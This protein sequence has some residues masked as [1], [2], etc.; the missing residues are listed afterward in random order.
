MNRA[1]VLLPCIQDFGAFSHIHARL[2]AAWWDHAINTS[3]Y[4]NAVEKCLHV[5]QGMTFDH[6]VQTLRKDAAVWV[7]VGGAR[8]MHP[9]IRDLVYSGG[10]PCGSWFLWL[11]SLSFFNWLF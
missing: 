5:T 11:V 10:F 8:E 3:R 9:H 6:V 2:L 7:A 1:T 4:T